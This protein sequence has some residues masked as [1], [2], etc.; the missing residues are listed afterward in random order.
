MRG[1]EEFMVPFIPV[2]VEITSASYTA[3]WISIALGVT[4][5]LI[6]YGTYVLYKEIKQRQKELDEEDDVHAE[7]QKNDE[8]ILLI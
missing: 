3:I 5:L 4:G 7:M 2:K 1:D 6:V 8:E